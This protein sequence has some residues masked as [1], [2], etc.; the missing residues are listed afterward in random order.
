[1]INPLHNKLSD[2]YILQVVRNQVHEIS[3]NKTDKH[4]VLRTAQGEHWYCSAVV[5]VRH[6]LRSILCN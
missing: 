6:V 5:S 4:V 2:F 3:A 1:M